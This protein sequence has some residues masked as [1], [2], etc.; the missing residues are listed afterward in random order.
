MCRTTALSHFVVNTFNVFVA[1]VFRHPP[2]LLYC[3]F[4][5]AVSIRAAILAAADSSEISRNLSKMLCVNNAK[6]G[7]IYIRS[8]N[9]FFCRIKAYNL[10][11]SRGAYYKGNLCIVF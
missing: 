2:W 5:I 8:S 10:S 9:R 3:R 7:L 4:A 11:L 1:A 6:F